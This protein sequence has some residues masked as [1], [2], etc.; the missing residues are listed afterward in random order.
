MPLAISSNKKSTDSPWNELFTEICKILALDTSNQPLI[1]RKEPSDSV[2]DTSE[3]FL[4][5][6]EYNNTDVL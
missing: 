3:H 4:K 1:R 2:Y 5:T 6:K